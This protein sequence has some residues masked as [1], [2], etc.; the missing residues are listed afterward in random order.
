MECK[1]LKKELGKGE[2]RGNEGKLRTEKGGGERKRRNDKLGRR[3]N[4][5]RRD[6]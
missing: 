5:I 3:E 1:T 2:M 4:G 6:K